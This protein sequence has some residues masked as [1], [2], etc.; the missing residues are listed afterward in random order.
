MEYSYG[1]I[2]HS[3]EDGGFAITRNNMAENMLY[4]LIYVSIK[5]GKMNA[6]Y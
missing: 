2:L 1:G 5:M 4:D 6:C 3:N